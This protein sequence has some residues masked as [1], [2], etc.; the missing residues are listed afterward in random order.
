M[1]IARRRLLKLAGLG[2]LA[3][4]VLSAEAETFPSRPVTM[5]VPFTAGG[6]LDTTGR[7]IA[8]RMRQSLGQPL[9]IENIGGAGGSIGVGRVAHAAPDGYT[10][11]LEIWTTAVVNGA[12]YQLPYDVQKD[13]APIGLVTDGPLVIVGRKTFPADDLKGLIAWLKANPDKA[14][15]GTSGVGS[16]QHISGV[17]FQQVTGTRFQFVHY[18]GGAQITQDL[19]AG[20]IDI[21][22]SDAITALPQVRAGTIKAF[23]FMSKSRSA[24]APDIPTVDEAGLPGFYNS[25]WQGIWAPAGTPADI[26]AKLNSALVETLDD[27][28]I[29]KRLS[30]I[31]RSVFPREQ[32]TPQALGALQKAEIEKWWPVIKAAGVK[33]E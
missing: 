11:V 33:G 28:A 7:I 8:E 21:V 10:I 2:V 3:A 18:R 20:Q 16:P 25:V 23:A 1:R 30:D 27:P 4:P 32:M 31:G 12:I 24:V 9:I 19:M 17:L 13:F 26:I 6:P 15:A 5:V 29:R 14:T 22:F